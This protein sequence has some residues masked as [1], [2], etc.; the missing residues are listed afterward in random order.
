[1]GSKELFT[2]I[3]HRMYLDSAP[4]LR[5]FNPKKKVLVRP[6]GCLTHDDAL[7]ESFIANENTIP[8]F[9]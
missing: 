3:Y 5:R 7:V 8:Y 2:D 6:A 1:M 4:E 9:P